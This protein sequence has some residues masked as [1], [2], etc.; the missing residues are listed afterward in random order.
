MHRPFDKIDPNILKTGDIIYYNARQDGNIAEPT[1]N[2]YFVVMRTKQ[3]A[4][5][6]ILNLLPITHS[7]KEKSFFSKF[8]VPLAN[9]NAD[10]QDYLNDQSLSTDTSY[11]EIANQIDVNTNEFNGHTIPYVGNIQK[12]IGPNIINDIG[13][14]VKLQQYALSDRNTEYHNALDKRKFIQES[15][16]RREEKQGN[17]L[18]D[19]TFSQMYLY[20]EVP[21]GD[22]SVPLKY[23]YDLHPNPKAYPPKP[24][25][26]T[27]EKEDNDSPDP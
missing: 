26:K 1:K 22:K 21:D 7:Q 24:S 23:P 20:K 8:N 25:S 9:V 16:K 14:Q 6:K 19:E 4:S 27:K 5:S 17:W 13:H 18:T 15:D 12:E 2:R 3:H 11:F 10:L